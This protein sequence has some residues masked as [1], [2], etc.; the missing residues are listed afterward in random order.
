[1]GTAASAFALLLLLSFG[2]SSPSHDRPNG[3]FLEYI[4][5]A[6]WTF[7]I[8]IIIYVL[9]FGFSVYQL[10]PGNLVKTR[11]ND[12]VFNQIGYLVAINFLSQVLWMSIQQENNKYA[13]GLA[14]FF[15]IVMLFTCFWIMQAANRAKLNWIEMVVIRGGFSLYAGWIIS[16]T[17]LSTVW[18]CNT[19]GV[20]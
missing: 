18:F 13:I 11:N 2:K 12:L 14:H 6:G 15:M 3:E 16:A 5:P 7:T 19:I 20:A 4:S 8:W 17:V 10:L 1:M 9:I